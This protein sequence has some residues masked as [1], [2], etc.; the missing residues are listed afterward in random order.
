MIKIAIDISPTIDNNSIR[1][2]GYYT[3][4]L[5]SS[6]QREIKRDPKYKNWQI[7]LIAILLNQRSRES[8]I[9]HHQNI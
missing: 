4:H 7:D 1:G 6:L 3:K 5:V 8:E 2:V 9:K